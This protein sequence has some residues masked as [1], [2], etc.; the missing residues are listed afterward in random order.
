[1]EEIF[2]V[3]T[4]LFECIKKKYNDLRKETKDLISD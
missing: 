4:S 3:I 2:K 1:M